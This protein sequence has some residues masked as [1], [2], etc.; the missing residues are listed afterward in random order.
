[1]FMSWFLFLIFQYLFQCLFNIS[2][3]EEFELQSGASYFFSKRQVLEI[4]KVNFFSCWKSCLKLNVGLNEDVERLFSIYMH[5]WISESFMQ[6][7]ITVHRKHVVVFVHVDLSIFAG[8][9]FAMYN[10][11]RKSLASED[12]IHRRTFGRLFDKHLQR[13]SYCIQCDHFLFFK[14]WCGYIM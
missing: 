9:G 1:M 10:I 8:Q 11:L 14:W 5:L 6:V 7:W 12:E 4:T 3:D 2:C 13:L